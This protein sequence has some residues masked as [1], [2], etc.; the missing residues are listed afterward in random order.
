MNVGIYGGSFDPP[1]IGHLILAEYAGEQ[2]G[3]QE[4][5][6]IPSS[7]PP[8]KQGVSMTPPEH[9]LA[10]VRL[11]TER[12]PRFVVSDSEIRRGGVSY[13]VETIEE[14]HRE[15]PGDALFFLL[16]ADNLRDFD[17][18]RN[19]QRILE[20]VTLVVMTRPGFTIAGTKYAS[21]AQVRTL[22]VP[23]IEVASRD[24]RRRVQQGQSIQYLVPSA[25]QDYI[26]QHRLYRT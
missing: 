14:L 18:W 7:V 20:L 12:N 9:R 25:V 5:L 4:V 11:A 8:H 2:L 23:D 1:H 21:S 24:I 19:P 3:L 6:F 22:D 10:M 15:R 13:T 26:R 16:G 17:T